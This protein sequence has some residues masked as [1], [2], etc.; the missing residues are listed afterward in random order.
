MISHCQANSVVYL[1]KFLLNTFHDNF[2]D[3]PNVLQTPPPKTDFTLRPYSANAASQ[4][5]DH[6]AINKTYNAPERP[7]IELPTYARRCI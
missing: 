3:C 1:V 5:G 2:Y 7:L 6:S 4:R